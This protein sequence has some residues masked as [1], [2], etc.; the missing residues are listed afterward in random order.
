MNAPLVQVRDAARWFDVSAPWLERVLARKPRQMLRAVDGVS[1]EIA[2]GETLALVGESGC[3]KSTVARMLVGLYGLTRGAIQFDGQPLS[4]LATPQGKQLRSRL[5]MIFQDPYASL[6]PRWRVGRIIAE[7]LLT[8]ASLA[9]AQRQERVGELLRQVG[10]DPADQHR[11]P[12]QFSGG[13]RQRLCIAR[14][15]V[16]DPEVLV[17]DEAVSALD[18][19]VQAQVLEL[20]EQVRERTGVSVLFI[21]HDLRVAAQVCDTIAV[22]QHGKVVE[23]G[24]AQT[25]LT[26][27]GHAYTRALIDA[28]PGRGWDFR[29]FRPLPA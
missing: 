19:S 4:A 17:A 22:M 27:P 9:P 29:N 1:F 7:P 2:R 13:Q 12:H 26:R 3:G 10:L 21:T 5:Q 16:M 20:I 24:A 28:A 18:V 14:A 23:T 11:Y 8:H 15:L 6:N 25:V